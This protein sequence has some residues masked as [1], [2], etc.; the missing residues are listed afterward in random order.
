MAKTHQLWLSFKLDSGGVLNISP[1][2]GKGTE[3]IL[4]SEIEDLKDKFA[5]YLSIFP[6]T[7]VRHV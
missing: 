4:S 5:Q 7:L 2:F 3:T 6:E 1:E